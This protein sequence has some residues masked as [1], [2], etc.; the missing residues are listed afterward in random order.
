MEILHLIYRD[1]KTGKIWEQIGGQEP[2]ELSEE[3]LKFRHLDISTI[4]VINQGETKKVICQNCGSS[5]S[6]T[7][8]CPVCGAKLDK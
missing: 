8:F 3:D 6:M 5:V 1:K 7:A 4:P 2:R